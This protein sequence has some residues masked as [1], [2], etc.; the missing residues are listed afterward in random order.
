MHLNSCLFR[1]QVNQVNRESR[2]SD[3][4]KGNWQ[5]TTTQSY[6]VVVVL[7]R[8]VTAPS[9]TMPAAGEFNVG[10]GQ[11]ASHEEILCSSGSESGSHSEDEELALRR[12]H[13]SVPRSPPAGVTPEP[14]TTRSAQPNQLVKPY[15]KSSTSD[16]PLPVNMEDRCQSQLSREK[17]EPFLK[18]CLDELLEE[19]LFKGISKD[20]KVLNWTNPEE[21]SQVFDMSLHQD[22]QSD[23]QLLEAIR[24]TIKYSVKTGHP[25]F[26]NQLFST[27]DPYGLIGQWTTDALNPSVY[28]YEVSPV[29]TLMEETVLR[30]MRKIVGFSVDGEGDGIF[31]PGGSM[32]NGYAISC[33]RYKAMPDVKVGGSVHDMI[34]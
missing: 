5:T 26:V 10:V 11:K 23:E 24:K 30:E 1:S 27:V 13:H 15:Q 12:Y 33:A 32:A 17:H 2:D 7:R 14:V 21:L 22:P 29:F 8:A 3:R 6:T 20:Q 25:Y 34:S 9:V 16:K 31:V 28:T 4:R 19:A 18:R